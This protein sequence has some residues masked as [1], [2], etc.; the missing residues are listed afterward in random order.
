MLSTSLLPLILP[1]LRSPAPLIC[2]NHLSGSH[3]LFSLVGHL[4]LSLARRL[5]HRPRASKTDSNETIPAIL[6]HYALVWLSIVT[7]PRGR[8]LDAWL[9]VLIVMDCAPIVISIYYS[10]KY[11]W[12]TPVAQEEVFW[13]LTLF[14]REWSP[15]YQLNNWLMQFVDGCLIRH[16]YVLIMFTLFIT[17]CHRLIVT[18]LYCI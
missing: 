16:I 12:T 13:R 5:W 2:Y 3:A 17:N 9:C 14:M 1:H 11:L 8:Q 15:A 4:V 7:S 18:N 10:F 6:Q